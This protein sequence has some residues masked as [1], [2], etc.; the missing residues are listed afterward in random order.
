MQVFIFAN[1]DTFACW[2]FIVLVVGF[3]FCVFKFVKAFVVRCAYRNS[4]SWRVFCSR[5][6]SQCWNGGIFANAKSIFFDLVVVMTH[7]S[8]SVCFYLLKFFGRRLKSSFSSVLPFRLPKD[9]SS[10][11]QKCVY[12]LRALTF[13][14]AHFAFFSIFES[15]F[16]CEILNERERFQTA[17]STKKK[18]KKRNHINR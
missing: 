14:L 11:F 4:I 13:S 16:V 17:N 5:W 12:V 2:M 10:A 8:L 15:N 6:M 7:L 18:R 1:V 3:F 9:D